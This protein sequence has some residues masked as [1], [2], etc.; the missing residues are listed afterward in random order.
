METSSLAINPPKT[1]RTMGNAMLENP[2]VMAEAMRLGAKDQRGMISF[3]KD[4]FPKRFAQISFVDY[5][6]ED[7][8]VELE[9]RRPLDIQTEEVIPQ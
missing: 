6:N 9:T 7:R 4:N 8:D 1:R 2:E 5:R 3:L